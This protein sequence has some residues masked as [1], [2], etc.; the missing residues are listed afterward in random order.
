MS[1]VSDNRQL[2]EAG[3]FFDIWRLLSAP[4]PE[5]EAIIRSLCRTVYLGSDTAL[6]RI[7][8]R[9]KM[10][11][12]TRDVSISSH[13]LLEGFWE[14][15]VTEAMLRHVKPGMTV[16]DIG[17][18]LGYF[19]LL[20]ADLVGPAG[21]VLA[22]EPNPEMASRAR[23]SISINGF[24]PTTTL[25]EIALADSDGEMLLDV[26]DSSPGGAHLV[27][28]SAAAAPAAAPPR[29]AGAPMASS[30]AA[31]LIT[32]LRS[33]VSDAIAA[34]N[35]EINHAAQAR[36][37]AAVVEVIAAAEIAAAA[38]Q[39]A[40]RIV[41][42]P[43]STPAGQSLQSVPIRR[44]DEIEGAL[45]ADFIKMDVE[46]AEQMVWSGMGGL[47]ARGRPLT[48]FMEFTISRFDRPHEFLDA[49]ER[50]GFSMSIVTYT[51]GVVPISREQLF[52]QSHF[53]D[54][55]LVFIRSGDTADRA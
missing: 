53:V 41:G 19:T 37:E 28:P 38:Q 7:L 23:R 45:D 16:L 9:Y 31:P 52:S 20:L 30:L 39:P 34:D 24:S 50:N 33:V 25:H 26:V 55:M 4:R 12:D 32:I 40:D 13:L 36:I 22:F 2:I 42:V 47:L 3:Q 48:I 5:N 54:N 29:S 51:E 15:W 44:L 21:K 46:G 35:A 6:C 17:A 43:K 14:M 49:I 18:N 27:A 1:D 11:V 10:Y 8:G